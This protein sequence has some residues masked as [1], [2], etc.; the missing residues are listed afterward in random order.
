MEIALAAGNCYASKRAT[1]EEER[2]TGKR[3]GEWSQD[4]LSID[5]YVHVCVCA[6]K[7]LRANFIRATETSERNKNE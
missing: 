5:M 3:E 4:R 1:A 6:E 2:V 7:S